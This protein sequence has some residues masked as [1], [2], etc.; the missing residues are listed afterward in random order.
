M[1]VFIDGRQSR[2]YVDYSRAVDLTVYFEYNSAKVTERAREVL[3]RLGEALA[4][5]E[6]AR[7]RFLIA[8][9][10]DAVG[11]DEFNLDLSYKRAEAVKEYLARVHG[12]HPHRVAVKGWGR[13]RLKD[14]MHPDAAVNRRVEVALIVDRGTTYLDQGY[15]T[16]VPGRRP[17]FTCPP[18]SR[19]IDPQRPDMN[20]D[21]FAAGVPN[22]MCRPNDDGPAV[23]R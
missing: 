7:H 2:A 12:I 11:T 5:P 15:A 10:T 20:L 19:L 8:G 18:G 22:P 23:P 1:D 3:D 16:Q 6:L 21:D 14:R 13:S 17:M 9:H 4:S